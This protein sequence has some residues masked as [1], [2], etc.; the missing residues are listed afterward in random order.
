MVSIA[1][2]DTAPR[3]REHLETC[4]ATTLILN[5]PAI[6]LCS[7]QLRGWA[8]PAAAALVT[9]PV[10]SSGEGRW[11]CV[12]VLWPQPPSLRP[13]HSQCTH[14]S[15]SLRSRTRLAWRG[16]MTDSPV[17]PLPA[18]S[19]CMRRPTTRHHQ[20]DR[21][22]RSIS[23]TASAAPFADGPTCCCCW[24]PPSFGR[25]CCRIRSWWRRRT[26]H[27][28]SRGRDDTCTNKAQSVGLS[29]MGSES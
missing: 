15:L 23:A 6:R 14:V 8:A 28:I 20:P 17:E 18:A 25:I 12:T 10:C 24:L 26:G 27:G 11:G 29:L 7:C 9:R 13:C 5:T 22:G 21:T 3:G 19:S 2:F 4:F 1:W 16:Y